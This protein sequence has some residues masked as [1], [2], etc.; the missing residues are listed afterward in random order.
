MDIVIDPVL[1]QG[2]CAAVEIC[3]AISDLNNLKDLDVIIFGRGGGSIEELWAFN[4]ETVARAI[5]NSKIPIIS[6]VGHETDYTIADFVA[7]KR[8]PTPSAAGE[9]VVPEK[10]MLKNE[11]RHISLRLI[12]GI[13][14]Y[15][16][17]KDKKS[18]ILK[19][20]SS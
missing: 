1:V 9:I 11:I 16:S 7:D 17:E 4:E 2:K 8:A 5:A 14:N 12:N 6:A 10:R 20:A 15:I 19:N 13:L 3:S 18:S